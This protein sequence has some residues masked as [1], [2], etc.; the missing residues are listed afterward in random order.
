MAANSRIKPALGILALIALAATSAGADQR[1][2]PEGRDQSQY[3]TQDRSIAGTLLVNGR[4]FTIRRSNFK[5]QI[6]DAFRIMGYHA[7]R[8]NGR[9][10]VGIEHRR[11]SVSW[12]G[13]G[14]DIRISRNGDY[15]VLKPRFVQRVFPSHR[16]PRHQRPAI[17]HRPV[18]PAGHH[19]H[20]D[21][22]PGWPTGISWSV[23]VA[24]RWHW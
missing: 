17:H 21:I 14:T 22:H 3:R 10:Y 6:I 8:D 20:H 4:V 13:Q 5:Q 19:G 11:P 12:Y 16:Y 23:G 9:V 2:Y 18:R 1:V 24:G 7:W 15:L